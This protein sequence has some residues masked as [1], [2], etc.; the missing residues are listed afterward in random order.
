V[1]NKKYGLSVPQLA[2]KERFT[3]IS[4]YSTISKYCVDAALM[5]NAK[6]KMIVMHPL[7]RNQEIAVEVDKDPRAVYFKQMKYGLYMRMAILNTLM[8]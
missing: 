2:K 5:S 7:P 8:H 3:D 1:V 6:E 4:L